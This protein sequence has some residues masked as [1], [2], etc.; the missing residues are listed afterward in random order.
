MQPCI[1]RVCRAGPPASPWPP[2]PTL[3]VCARPG[4]LQVHEVREGRPHRRLGLR[5]SL[6]EGQ[7]VAPG[8]QQWLGISA[9]G[10][11][12][13]LPGARDCQVALQ[14]PRSPGNK[15]GGRCPPAPPHVASTLHL[16]LT[17]EARTAPTWDATLGGDGSSGWGLARAPFRSS[18]PLSAGG[19]HGQGWAPAGTESQNPPPRPWPPAPR[20]VRA[21]MGAF[22]PPF[23]VRLTRTPTS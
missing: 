1:E 9:L 3:A 16:T 10:T 7:R 18:S 15:K 17:A 6:W 11:H 8:G 14:A 22:Q 13:G 19:D 21:R 5:L 4:R 23:A 20:T 12:R 2:A